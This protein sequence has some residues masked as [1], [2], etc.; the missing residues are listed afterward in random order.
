MQACCRIRKARLR[1]LLVAL[2]FSIRTGRAEQAARHPLS[3]WNC[4]CSSWGR[5]TLIPFIGRR[6]LISKASSYY[7]YTFSAG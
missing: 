1:K 7:M 4:T 6:S 3:T 5:L 2:S